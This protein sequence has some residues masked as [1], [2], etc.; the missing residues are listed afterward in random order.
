M[1]ISASCK[2]V[3]RLTRQ[4]FRITRTKANHAHFSFSGGSK[5]RTALRAATRLVPGG[6]PSQ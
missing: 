2:A 5:I 6:A 3:P 4:E 1:R